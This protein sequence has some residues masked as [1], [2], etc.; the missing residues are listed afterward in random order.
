MA[1]GKYVTSLSAESEVKWTLFRVGGLTNREQNPVETTFL[2]SGKDA[3]WISRPSVARWVLDEAVKENFSPGMSDIFQNYAVQLGLCHGFLMDSLLAFTCLH[4]AAEGAGSESNH[5][6]IIGDAFRYQDRALPA[7]RAELEQISSSNCEAL[8]LCSMIMMACA[9]ISPSFDTSN[10]SEPERNSK[11]LHPSL[12]SI[13]FFAKGIHSVIDRARPWLDESPLKPAIQLYPQEYWATS[14]P[15]GNIIPFELRKI[16]D[17]TSVETQETCRRA[18]RM[19]EN[20][21]ARDESM[22]L[23]W[24]VEVG[25][26]FMSRVQEKE[27]IALLVYICWGALIGCSKE[28]WWARLAGQTV[29]K[30]LASIVPTTSE[31]EIIILNWAREKVAI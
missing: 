29:V 15:E 4:K 26:G 9:A 28:L 3:M 7:F 30:R 12:T 27:P 11:P 1:V 23:A 24:V 21:S 17:A 16:C 18:I 2:G 10:D 5:L 8:L 6:P 13:F 25:E 31:E 19:L 20:C 14:P 22:A